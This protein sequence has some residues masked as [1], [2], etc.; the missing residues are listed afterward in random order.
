M[1]GTG[2]TNDCIGYINKLATFGAA[3]S[4]GKLV[5]SALSGGYGNTNYYFDD[6]TD[7]RII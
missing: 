7:I 6:T 1:N 3:F 2:G 4:P 5:I